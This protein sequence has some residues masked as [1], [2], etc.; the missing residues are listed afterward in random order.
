MR[1][2]TSDPHRCGHVPNRRFKTKRDDDDF[3]LFVGQVNTTQNTFSTALIYQQHWRSWI[4]GT[5]HA[6]LRGCLKRGGGNWTP[7][8]L[9]RD[10]WMNPL[11]DTSRGRKQQHDDDDDDD[12]DI[13]YVI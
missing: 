6:R 10:G 2:K 13:C 5:T 3:I 12:D 11:S 1:W 4:C 9:N 7:P 8:E